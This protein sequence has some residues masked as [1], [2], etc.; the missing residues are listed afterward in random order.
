MFDLVRKYQKI[1]LGIILLGIFPAFVFFGLSGY[2]QMIGGGDEV[3][4][5]EGRKISRPA[6]EQAHRQ[7]IEQL[8]QMLGGQVDTRMFDTPAARRQTLEQL[9]TQEAMLAEVRRRYITVPPSEVQKNI[10][11]IQGLTG[12]DGKFDFERYRTLLAQQNMSPAMFEA[13]MAQDLALRQLAN[14]VQGTV[15][16]PRA[17][18]DRL[19]ELQESRRTVRSRLIDPK[20]LESGIEPTDEEINRFYED[21]AAAFQLP[22][23]V[24]IEYVLLDRSALADGIKPSEDEL[25]AYYEQ[26][27]DRFADPEQRR[28]S[29]ILVEVPE[30]ADDAAKAAARERAEKLLAQVKAAP[31]KFA[32]IA[33]EHSDDPGSK[34]QGGDLGF[35]SR[36]MMVAP[37]SDAAFAMKEGEISDLVRSDYGF[38]IIQVTGAKGSGVRPFE[39]AKDEIESLYREQAAARRY[40]ELAESF[41][42][43]V[44][45]QSD[46]LQPAVE[47]YQLEL[48]RQERL[49]RNPGPE[50]PADSPLRNPRFVE[51]VFGEEALQRK[52]NTEAFEVAP[53]VMI[54]ARVTAHHPAARQ[55]LDAIRD[56]VRARVIAEQAAARAREQ[57]RKLLEELK[58]DT[59]KAPEGFGEPVTVS[60]A[61]PGNLPPQALAEAFR[62]APAPLP[63]YVGVDLGSRGYQIVR[64]EKVEGPDPANEGRREQYAAQAG[65]LLAQTALAA[66]IEQ[67]KART[68][69][70]RRLR[71]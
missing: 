25:R 44:Y 3:A 68:D 65:Q 43:T 38:H 6:F 69:I 17:V 37:F 21:N 46:S 58:A 39:Q 55:P 48:R 5:V 31:D 32:D 14:A 28:A 59:A 70:E 33:R 42:N 45:E 16:V 12:A 15:I 71:D 51:M 34:E 23:S 13:Q 4:V 30:S 49:T 47:K 66:Y 19:F 64:V 62:L 1:M 40:S 50:I 11:A 22:E 10:L 60:R 53:G 67:V 52:R 2:E 35:F 61:D 54:S 9:I 20:A 7:Q 36:D 41:T 8:Q 57:G 18:A 29:H 26:N 56:E 27:R 24:D 63:A